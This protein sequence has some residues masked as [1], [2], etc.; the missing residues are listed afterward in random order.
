MSATNTCYYSNKCQ[1]SKA[2]VTELAK[3]PWKNSFRFIC[4]DASPTRPQLPSW[5]KKVPTIVVAGEPE[6]RTDS[7]VM[8]WLYEKRMKEGQQ[9]GAPSTSGPTASAGGAE[10]EAF[11]MMEQVS[12]AKG[13]SYSGLDVD[14]SSQGTGGTS[15]PGAF[16][17]LGGA[18]AEGDKAGQGGGAATQVASQR[19]SKKEELFDKQM[20]AYQR[21]REQGMPRQAAG[22]L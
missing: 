9:Q 1:W 18:A 3:T 11:S 22:R 17:F 12:F 2:F 5:L 7:D 13:F 8:N 4:V 20:E 19:R 15:M 14:T 10:P 16:S 21:D 6:P